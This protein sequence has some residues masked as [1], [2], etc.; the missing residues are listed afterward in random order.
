MLLC[1]PGSGT[2][3]NG[4]KRLHPVGYSPQYVVKSLQPVG[5]SADQTP[6]SVYPFHY[7]PALGSAMYGI[8]A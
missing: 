1:F 7:L 6:G 5:K 8:N 2:L 4:K 3:F